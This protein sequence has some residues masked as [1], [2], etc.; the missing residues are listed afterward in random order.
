MSE[1]SPK[2]SFHIIAKMMNDT[3][4]NVMRGAVAPLLAWGWAS[5]AVSITVWVGLWLTCNNKWNFA[6]FLIPLI[7]MPLLRRLKPAEQGVSTAIS[8]SLVVIWKM[9]T[10]LIVAFSVTS[11]FVRYN[12]LSFILL[13]L[14][15]GSFITGELIRYPFLKYSSVAGFILAASMWWITGLNQIP[16]FAMAM[17]IMMIIPAY[18]IRHELK[19]ENNARA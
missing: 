6:W 3:R 11:F 19:T 9:L 17:L 18:R 15:I 10:V 8:A 2:E 5:F 7:G 1:M 4:H 16:V 14:A 13:I 12:V